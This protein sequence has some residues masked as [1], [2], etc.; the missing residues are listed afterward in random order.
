MS[1]HWV[2]TLA[3][4]A[5]GYV[6]HPVA[7]PPVAWWYTLPFAAL[8]GAVVV[9][10]SVIPRLWHDNRF[11]LVLSASLAA[12]ALPG[13]GPAGLQH[14]AADYIAF[15]AMVGSLFVVAGHVHIEGHWVGRPIP[16]AGVLVAGALLANLLGTTGAS[17]LLVR[18]ILTTNEW[19]RHR[20]HVPVFFI[21]MVSNT[22]GLLTP[23]GDPPLFIGFLE[24]VPFFWTLRLWPAWLL[25]NG[26]V[27][28]IFL[29]V[30]TWQFR[31]EVRP[32]SFGRHAVTV[33]GGG[34][35]VFLAGIIG[36]VLLKGWLGEGIWALGISSALMALMGLLAYATSPPVLRFETGFSWEPVLE[37]GALF[38][39]LFITMMPAM[40][41]LEHHAADLPV[42]RPW[43]FFWV[44]G[45]LSSLL[46]NAPT[47]AVLAV[48]ART[49][50][51]P[52]AA[53]L[54]GLAADSAGSA[55][56]AAICCGAVFM[57]ANTYIGNGPNF[58]VRTI[59][60]A[61][62][63]PMPGFLAYLC[64]ALMVLGPVFLLATFLLFAG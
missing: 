12:C 19:R 1:A 24:G 41:L 25:V 21:F 8:L 13:I 29:A 11:K 40:S 15:M 61:R 4:L 32:G 55:L 45:A 58:M 31:R 28:A 53:N 59:A 42:S 51:T 17:M 52:E 43:H 10:P 22:G 36:A 37:V 46:D 48:V 39:G 50:A 64:L 63:Y 16:N 9:L 49:Q 62:G 7:G 38:L 57:G 6:D 33:Q 26:A 3:G 18:L 23:L 56:L 44:T 35:L 2:L 47:Y 30:D 14:A 5:T 34:N 20:W 60:E 27:L 54:A